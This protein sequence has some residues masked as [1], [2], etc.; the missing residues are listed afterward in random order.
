[1][2]NFLHIA[3]GINVLPL[4]IALQ[5]QPELW[6]TQNERKEFEGSSHKCTSD[7]W[8]RYNDLK[9]LDPAN[10]NTYNLEHDAVWHPAY[11]KL[12]QLRPI[13]FGLMERCEAVRLGGVMITKIPAGGHVL[14]HTDRGWHPDYYNMKVYV[15]IQSNP[16]CI[17]RVEDER[18]SMAAGEAW[19]F[20]NTKEHEVINE[21]ADDRMTLIVCM[22]CDG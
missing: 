1:M 18:V 5:M 17:N 13:I 7:I 12:P 3:S 19:F 8:V 4:R 15:P 11:A 6:N 10:Y 20:D 9:N 14:P 21:G 16:Q 22:R 2:K